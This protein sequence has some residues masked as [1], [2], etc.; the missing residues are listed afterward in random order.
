MQNTHFYYVLF[1]GEKN[2]VRTKLG[3]F[4]LRRVP[5]ARWKPEKPK[6]AKFDKKEL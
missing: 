6:D 5:F 1:E 4:G 3:P 2:T